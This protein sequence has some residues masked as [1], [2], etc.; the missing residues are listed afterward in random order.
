MD[1]Q[2]VLEE[3]R[4]AGALLEG[5]FILSS[6]LRSPVFLQKARVFADAERTARLCAALADKV[7]ATVTE[8]PDVIVSPAVGGIV[9]GYEMGR[10]MKLP[11]IY[12]EREDGE[13]RLRRGFELAEGE[14]VLVVEDIVTTGLSS[15][16]CIDSIKAT[17]ARV[18]AEACL[19]DR[20]GGKADVGVPLIALAT[21]EFPAYPADDLP[22]ELAAVPAIKPGSR[23]L[24][25]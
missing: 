12:V 19:I 5:H 4:G 24:Q 20:S 15:R 1:T 10:Q 7:R 25:K 16:E 8:M 2:D 13:F 22:P 11:A 21:V 17:G 14:K 23:G 3:F 18:L 6:G 9:P